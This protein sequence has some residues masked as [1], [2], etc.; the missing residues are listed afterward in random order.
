[1]LAASCKRR[2]EMPW[3]SCHR[4]NGTRNCHKTSC[5]M[6]KQVW[7]ETWSSCLLCES[8][9]VKPGQPVHWNSTLHPHWVKQH[10]SHGKLSLLSSCQRTWLVLLWKADLVVVFS[11]QSPELICEM[12]ALP[13]TNPNQKESTPS[14]APNKTG[15]KNPINELERYSHY[16]LYHSGAN[17]GQWH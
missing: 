3:K 2:K 15:A 12:T 11:Q 8:Q 16:L 9:D 10:L 1:M 6:E 7:F 4:E 5:F 14:Q 17:E 13:N